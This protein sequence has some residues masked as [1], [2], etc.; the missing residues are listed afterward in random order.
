MQ[1]VAF[2]KMHG[3]GN[4][5][6]VLD[7]RTG[8]LP[9]LNWRKLADRHFGI[10]CD[11][12]VVLE[13]SSAADVFMRIFNADGSEA[14][15]CGNASRCVAWLVESERAG[16]AHT[17]TIQTIENVLAA[18]VT[19]QQVTL[20]MG[21]P[22]LDWQDIPLATKHDTLHVPVTA[23][24][25]RDAV[26]VNM[27]NPHVVFFV[28]EGSRVSL[29]ELGPKLE[30]HRLFPQRTN[31]EVAQVVNHH[32]IRLRVWERGTGLTLACGTGACATLV[33][34]HRRGLT[35]RTA[36]IHLPGGVLHVQWRTSDD[37]VLMT[38]AVATSFTGVFDADEY[39]P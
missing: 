19:G 3:T 6:V 8:S 32:A 35:G 14:G 5:F 29:A 25:L 13:A 21:A 33:A 38:G 22:K 10:G 39:R 20:D 27:G 16:A 1:Q 11:Q 9:P 37:H 28:P 17:V 31:V 15:A 30:E 12:I 36:S 24:S 7:N 18:E 34:A 23:G 2:V 4:D 26:A